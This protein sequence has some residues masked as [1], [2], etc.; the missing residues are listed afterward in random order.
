MR[1]SIVTFKKG[2]TLKTLEAKAREKTDLQAAQEMQA[3]K[4]QL[5]AMFN[6]PEDKKRA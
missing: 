2:M 6:K 3:A 4:V 1:T 5:F